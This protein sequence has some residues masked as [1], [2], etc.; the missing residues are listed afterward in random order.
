MHVTGNFL[1]VE[2]VHFGHFN[3]VVQLPVE[4]QFTVIDIKLKKK[5]VILSSTCNA[6]AVYLILNLFNRLFYR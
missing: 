3:L 5:T 1:F 6:W 4:S 2:V